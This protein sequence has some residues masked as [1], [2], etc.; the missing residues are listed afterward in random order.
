MAADRGPAGLVEL[1]CPS[2]GAHL[3]PGAQ[4]VASHAVLGCP[5]CGGSVMV[6]RPAPVPAAPLPAPAAPSRGGRTAVRLGLVVAL[7]AGGAGVGGAVL[8][9]TGLP[10]GP[11]DTY[12]T[13]LL[14]FGEPG[15]APGF[16]ADPRRIAVGP[17]GTIWVANGFDGRVAAFDA[18]GTF[19]REI[20]V[21]DPDE[22][23]MLVAGLAVDGDGDVHVT[24]RGQVRAF[25]GSD[26][27]EVGRRV[28]GIGGGHDALARVPDGD[29]VAVR[30]RDRRIDVVTIPDAGKPKALVRDAVRPVDPK[31]VAAL[32][33]VAVG[34]AG[35]V[36]LLSGDAPQVYRYGPDGTFSD[37][38]GTAGTGDGQLLVPLGIAVDPQGR[39]LVADGPALEVF[40]PSGEPL[41]TI[42]LDGVAM[43]VTT[44]RAGDV[45]VV[46]NT[47][48]VLKFSL[49]G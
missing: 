24:V 37:R 44:D 27:G 15:N 19:L 40:D 39:V 25:S 33:S 35:D 28:G 29:V 9:R 45:Y 34:G 46:T 10:A 12:G 48:R 38:F 18:E 11:S 47:S 6:G 22:D 30:D 3:R 42:P 49:D 43:G 26:G 41:G 32:L 1:E 17:D 31:D 5:Y 20:E 21:H 8:A 13:R 23:A 2:C 36:Y 14:E 7:L 4:E 16:L